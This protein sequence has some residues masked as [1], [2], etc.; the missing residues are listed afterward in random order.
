MDTY[1]QFRL[2]AEKSKSTIHRE[3]SD[4]MAILKWGVIKRGLLPRNPLVR[5]Q[6]PKRDDEI[7]V[8]PPHRMNLP[9]L[10]PGHL[11]IL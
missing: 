2:N 10:L 5:Y 7:I 8:P 4:I 1:V 9:E 6:K 11:I 3:L